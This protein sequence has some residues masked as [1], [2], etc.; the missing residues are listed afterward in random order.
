MMNLTKSSFLCLFCV[1]DHGRL[2]AFLR[3]KI[4]D[5]M[6]LRYSSINFGCL[7]CPRR[8]H[9]GVQ[10]RDSDL[11]KIVSSALQNKKV[12]QLS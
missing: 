12:D 8:V 7:I 10:L 2:C 5:I 11:A 1:Q 6:A 4:V 9:A 3:M